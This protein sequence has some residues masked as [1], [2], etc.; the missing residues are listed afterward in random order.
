LVW[1]WGGLGSSEEVVGCGDG[2]GDGL[3]GGEM[4]WA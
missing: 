1:F 3:Y 4:N 2:G